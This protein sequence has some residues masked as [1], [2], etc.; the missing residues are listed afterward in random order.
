MKILAVSNLYPPDVEGGYERGCAQVVAGLRDR[1][2][3]VSVLTSV[4]RRP[5][6]PEE[7]VVRTLRLADVFD[8]VLGK[9][10]APSSWARLSVSALWVDAANVFRL[11]DEVQRLKPDVVY[12]WNIQGIGGISLLLALQQLGQPWVMHLM[13]PVPGIIAA[14]RGPRFPQLQRLFKAPIKGA[15]ISCSQHVIEEIGRNG[16]ELGGG[17]ELIPN[18]VVGPRPTF[19]SRRARNGR[20]RILMASVVTRFKGVDVMMRAAALLRERGVRD[21]SVDIYGPV[22]DHSLYGTLNELDLGDCFVIKGEV[23]QAELM[24][25]YA[26]YDLFAFPTWEREAFGFA[27]LEAASRGCPVLMTATCGLAEWLVDGVHCLKAERTPEAFADVIERVVRGDMDLAPIAARAQRAVLR[28]FHL[29]QV[30]PR[31]ETVLS[32]A[33]AGRSRNGQ[34]ADRIHM[35]AV[36]AENL[37]SVIIDE[38]VKDA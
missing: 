25:K 33:A 26:D 10:S 14:L 16:V 2:H 9:P 38:A 3:A 19:V 30:L 4:P 13:D 5:S 21:F 17:V 28:D 15:Y 6:E 11:L 37:A 23:P 27:A 31:I 20:L 34:R 12:V 8:P 32:A 29:D 36:L 22:L 18:W 7:R 1:G 24:E 35:S